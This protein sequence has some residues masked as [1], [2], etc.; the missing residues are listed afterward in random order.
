ML[1]LQNIRNTLIFGD[2]Y[3]TFPGSGEV[4]LA[5]LLVF[6]LDQ[7]LELS[8]L[9]AREIEALRRLKLKLTN[10]Q[11]EH[12]IPEVFGPTPVAFSRRVPKDHIWIFIGNRTFMRDTNNWPP[13]PPAPTKNSRSENSE[14]DDNE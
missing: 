8:K 7:R 10:E 2:S 3:S 6:N 1:I 11:L 12:L 14:N 13:A 4:P 9:L 5:H